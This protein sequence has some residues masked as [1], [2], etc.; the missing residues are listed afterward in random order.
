MR[1]LI[2]PRTV[3][4]SLLTACAIIGA[5]L[6]ILASLAWLSAYAARADV[7]PAH[8][9]AQRAATATLSPTCAE[10]A[11]CWVWSR[12][13]NHRRGIVTLSGNVRV[14]GPC[15]FQRLWRGGHIRYS[16]RVGGK[17]YRNM[18]ERMRGDAWAIAH[19]CDPTH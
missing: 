7:A 18:L 16:V 13:G 5:T 19:G 15:A 4:A 10:D 17:V 8:V 3:R 14:V 9:G 12:M 2:I 1:S 6:L 11:P